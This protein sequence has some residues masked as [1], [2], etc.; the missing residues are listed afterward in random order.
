MDP[1][2]NDSIESLVYKILWR[3]YQGSS[4]WYNVN[5]V[6]IYSGGQRGL[7]EVENHNGQKIYLHMMTDTKIKSKGTTNF[8]SL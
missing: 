8:Y 7:G 5:L 6:V 2:P 4:T 3:F 1:W